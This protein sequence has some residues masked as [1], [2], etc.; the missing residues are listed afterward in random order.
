MLGGGSVIGL[1]GGEHQY[2]NAD[3]LVPCPT[4]ADRIHGLG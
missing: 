2:G 3:V 1:E 4:N